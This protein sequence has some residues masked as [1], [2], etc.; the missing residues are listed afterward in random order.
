MPKFIKR[1]IQNNVKPDYTRKVLSR[2]DH[3]TIAEVNKC[4]WSGTSNSAFAVKSVHN[5]YRYLLDNTPLTLPARYIAERQL[6][7]FLFSLARQ[8]MFHRPKLIGEHTFEHIPSVALEHLTP[9]EY[10]TKVFSQLKDSDIPKPPSPWTAQKRIPTWRKSDP[11]FCKHCHAGN[12]RNPHH[13]TN[14]PQ[15]QN[16]HTKPP[17]NYQQR[18]PN[19][20]NHRR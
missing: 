2:T 10:Q 15:N 14:S 9:S 3:R 8:H 20:Q 17:Q 16:Y 11:R 6:S 12:C 1:E 13:D 4:E 18:S 5:Y 19:Y 7:T